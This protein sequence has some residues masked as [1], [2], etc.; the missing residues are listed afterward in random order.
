MVTSSLGAMATWILSPQ[1]R[2][3]AAGQLMLLMCVYECLCVKD[4]MCF[5]RLFTGC[6]GVDNRERERE[7][8]TIIQYFIGPQETTR[9]NT[10]PSRFFIFNVMCFK[11]IGS[12]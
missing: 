5:N 12:V 10:F 7:R 9:T 11:C 3:F 4:S 2:I 6:N 8:I 1:L